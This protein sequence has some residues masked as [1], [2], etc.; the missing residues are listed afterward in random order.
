MA[1]PERQG[2]SLP[3]LRQLL[4]GEPRLLG[5]VIALACTYGF[6]VDAP[7]WNQNSRYALTRAIVEHGQLTIDEWHATTGDKSFR[8]GHF[9]CDKAPAYGQLKGDHRTATQ[10][11]YEAKNQHVE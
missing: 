10:A 6:F 5:F 1:E 2:L 4:G 3:G 8:E 7:S 9:Y 11:E